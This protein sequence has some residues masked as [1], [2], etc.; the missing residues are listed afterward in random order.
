VHRI[1]LVGAAAG[2]SL[3]MLLGFVGLAAG[4]A[5]LVSSDPAAG[6]SLASAPSQVTLTFTE[7]PDPALSTIKVLATDGTSVGAGPVSA[8]PGQPKE[9]RVALGKLQPGVYTVSWR[10][11]S[12]VDGHLASGSFAFGVGVA[13]PSAAPS[14]AA[15]AGVGGS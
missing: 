1:R 13:A 15:G 10:T 7:Q 12:T 14:L 8:V 5:L 9:L 6:A 11:V 3:A 4:H 2:V